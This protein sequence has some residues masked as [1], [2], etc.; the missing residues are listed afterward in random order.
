MRRR[1][2]V[3]ILV[4]TALGML[5]FFYRLGAK[6]LWER[7]EALVAVAAIQMLET[8]TS[9]VP[10]IFDDAPFVDNR[11][12]GYIWLVAATYGVTGWRNELGARLPSA[13]AA[14][15]CVLL[16]Y[17]MGRKFADRRLGFVSALILLGTLKF[18]WQARLA[19][20]DMLLALWTT[21][22]FWLFWQSIEKTGR[23]H[24]PVL[25]FQIVVGLGALTK[26]PGIVLTLLIPLAC[27]VAYSRRWRDVKWLALGLSALIPLVLGVGWYWSR[28]AKSGKSYCYDPRVRRPCI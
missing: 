5:L 3:H 6:D 13:I 20:V 26:G 23:A 24:W 15:A 10:R 25:G 27:Y 17:C 8:Q 19:E 28:A 7:S 11:P 2:V 22:G 18:A 1:D 9:L 14:L 12:P 21:L 16:V 4:L